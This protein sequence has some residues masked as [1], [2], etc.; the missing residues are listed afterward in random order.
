DFYFF[1][2]NEFESGDQYNK[3]LGD[4]IYYNFTNT[5]DWLGYFVQAEYSGDKI[6]AY[7]TFGNSYTKYSYVNHFVQDPTDATKELTTETDFMMGYQIKGGVAYRPIKQIKIFA[8]LGYISKAPIFDNVIN[9]RDATVAADPQNEIFQA[10]EGGILY[11][12]LNNVLTVSANYY[13]TA[14]LN[15]SMNIGITNQDGSEGYIFVNGMDQL[16][17]GYE[18]EAHVRPAKFIGFG[19]IGSIGNWVYLNDVQGT[20]KDYAGGTESDESYDFYVRGLKV[21]DAPQTQYAALIKLFPV[22]GLTIQIDGRYYTNYYADWDPFSRTNDDGL[23]VWKVPAYTLLD[24]HISYDFKIA[25]KFGFT[26]F[27]HMFNILDAVYV[28]DATD[29]SRYNAYPYGNSSHDANSAEVFL[30]LP[31]SFNVG[32]RFNF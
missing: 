19:L 23:Q 13:F 26:I 17:R 30:G 32:M 27:G 8:N 2:G 18:L 25:D 1:D 3:V 31:R 28:Q 22:K 12:T 24:G 9:D 11:K 16:H 6:T 7:G 14:W 10:V 21:G 29:N 20:Y 5:V 4:K 15:R